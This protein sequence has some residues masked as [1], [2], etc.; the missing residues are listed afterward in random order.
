MSEIQPGRFTGSRSSQDRRWNSIKGGTQRTW[1][2]HGTGL[3]CTVCDLVIT[4]ADIEHEADLSDGRVLRF[5]VACFTPWIA[6]TGRG[7]PP[8]DLDE[9][10]M[11]IAALPAVRLVPVSSTY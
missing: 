7:G 10:A 8:Q 2:G 11:M 5:H 9:G 6:E 1:A 4:P 3:R